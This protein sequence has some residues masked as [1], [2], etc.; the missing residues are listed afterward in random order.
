MIKTTITLLAI[1]TSY[2]L[3]LTTPTK[4]STYYHSLFL[5]NSLSD[6]VSI[7]N[8]LEILTHRPHIAGSEANNEAA[9]Y[10]VSVL[11]SCNILSHVTSYDVALTYPLSRS[12]VLKKSSSESSS[13]SFS[14]SQQVY[15]GDPYVDVADEVVPTFHGYAKSGTNIF[16]NSNS[17][18]ITKSNSYH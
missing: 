3:L 5:S 18:E 16:E 14:L 8:N 2:L 7:S 15:E 1:S 10:V 4:N 13:V 6:N 11:T 9:A 17:V 12:L